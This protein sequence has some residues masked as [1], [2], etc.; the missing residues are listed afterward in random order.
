MPPGQ[1]LVWGNH[2]LSPLL[3]LLGSLPPGSSPGPG[4]GGSWPCWGT[5]VA[6]WEVG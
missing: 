1:E 3:T 6:P 4:G 5:L 2:V